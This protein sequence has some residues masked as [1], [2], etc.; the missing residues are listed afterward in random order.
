[1]S[2]NKKKRF[3]D[4]KTSNSMNYR[5]KKKQFNWKIPKNDR[6]VFTSKWDHSHIRLMVDSSKSMCTKYSMQNRKSLASQ[7]N[8]DSQ[9]R[10]DIVDWWYPTDGL[11]RFFMTAWPT[12]IKHNNF[13][14]IALHRTPFHSY[15]VLCW[16]SW[17][18]LRTIRICRR[19]SSKQRAAA[20]TNTSAFS[21]ISSSSVFFRCWSFVFR[22][23][24]VWLAVLLHG[25]QSHWFVCVYVCIVAWIWMYECTFPVSFS[26]PKYLNE[27]CTRTQYTNNQF[28]CGF[29]FVSLICPQEVCR[30]LKSFV[31]GH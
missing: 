26:C 18:L 16:L 28:V 5:Q 29:Y 14:F 13:Y 19:R 8:A 3:S 24:S 21:M 23:L 20:V 7:R 4:T 31:F 1:M 10:Y 9:R 6:F 15:S 17:W 27:S 22:S 2:K 12:K 11:C 30:T 25:I